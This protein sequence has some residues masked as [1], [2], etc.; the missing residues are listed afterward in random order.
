M[1]EI[2]PTVDELSDNEVAILYNLLFSEITIPVRIAIHVTN[3]Q[4]W[5]KRLVS[6]RNLD[7]EPKE[8]KLPQ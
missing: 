3:L 8:N 4:K 2:V 6:A 1:A 7:K 5:V